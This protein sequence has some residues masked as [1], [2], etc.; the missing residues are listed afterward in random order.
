MGACYDVSSSPEVDETPAY[1]VV[2]AGEAPNGEQII[3]NEDYG[4]IWV[5]AD[6]YSCVERPQGKVG[7]TSIVRHSIMRDGVHTVIAEV[8]ATVTESGFSADMGRVTADDRTIAWAHLSDPRRVYVMRGGV[9]TNFTLPEDGPDAAGSLR[10][11]R[12]ELLVG[13]DLAYSLS[14]RR[15]GVGR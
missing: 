5:G 14:G 13:R 2:Q 1:G 15:L 10:L 9:I 11:S 3:M 7:D 4:C 6:V 8:E 12:G